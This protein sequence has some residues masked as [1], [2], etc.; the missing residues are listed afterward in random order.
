[1]WQH[2]INAVLWDRQTNSRPIYQKLSDRHLYPNG[3]DLMNNALAEEMLN[4]HA[5]HLLKTFQSSLRRWLVLK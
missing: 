3:A 5:L 1:M 2:W 4:S